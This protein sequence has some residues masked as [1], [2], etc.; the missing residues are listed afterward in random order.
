M[1]CPR[2]LHNFLNLTFNISNFTT[3]GQDPAMQSNCTDLFYHISA[4][5]IEVIYTRSQ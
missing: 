1:P 4:K 2:N 3:K 5:L